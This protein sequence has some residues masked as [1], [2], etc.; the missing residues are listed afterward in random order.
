MDLEDELC[1]FSPLQEAISPLPESGDDGATS[2]QNGYFCLRDTLSPS[3]SRMVNTFP[4]IDVFLT[5]TMSPGVSSYAPAT[6]PVT[7]AL[8]V[9]S[10]Y[11]SPGSPTSMDRFLAGD[12]L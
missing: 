12:S 11:V 2:T 4:T 5:Y 7:P 8:P 9:D 6:S 10:D 1:H 3:Q